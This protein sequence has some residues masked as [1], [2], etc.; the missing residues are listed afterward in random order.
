[1]APDHHTRVLQLGPKIALVGSTTNPPQMK[2]YL[3]VGDDPAV[4]ND[5]DLPAL[6]RFPAV[7]EEAK[8]G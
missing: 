8:C 5:Q 4:G 3:E 2:S 7:L 6:E 1:M